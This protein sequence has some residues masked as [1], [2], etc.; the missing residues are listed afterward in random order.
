MKTILSSRKHHY[1][2]KFSIFLI[3]VALVTGLVGCNGDQYILT[4]LSTEGGEVTSPGEGTSTYP[5]GTVVNL[6][7]EAEEGYRFVKWTGR[8]VGSIANVYAAETTINMTSTYSITAHFVQGKEIR[9]WKDLYDIRENLVGSHVLM[10][11]LDYTIAGYE[12]LAS[13]TANEGKGW[14]PIG[15]FTGSFDGQGYEIR[16][17]FID[18]PSRTAVGLFGYVGEGGLVED[19]GVVNANVTGRYNVGG[20]AGENY[21]T[22]NSSNSTGTVTGDDYVGGL[23]GLNEGGSVINSHSTSSVSGGSWVGGL[24]GWNDWIMS[25]SYS[26]GSVNGT[27]KVGGLVGLN[28]GTVSS[29]SYS[30]GNVTGTGEH[31]G[32]LVGWNEGT[33]SDSHSSSNVTGSDEHVGGLVGWNEGTV[34]E[35]SYST[36]SVK[37]ND[38][39]GG[40]V[41]FN[42]HG[43]TV[44][45]SHSIGNVI[46]EE[47]SDI[48][49]LVGWNEGNVENSYSSSSVSGR[50]CV[51]GLVGCNGRVLS[52]SD[53][54]G[55][56]S[57]SSSTGSVTGFTYVGGLVGANEGTVEE[58]YYSTGSV[59]GDTYVGGLVGA[60]EGTVGE[61]YS[62]GS[63]TG[64]PRSTRVGG[65][66]GYNK[67][68]EHSVSNSYSTGNVSG[69]QYVGG[70]VGYNEQSSVENSYS[71]GTVNGTDDV[72]GL[73]GE[74]NNG[75]APHSFW[76]TQTSGQNDS[77]VGTGKTT[78]EMM[79]I[80]TFSGAE[81]EWDIVRVALGARNRGYIWNI[82][83]RVAYP[84][85]SWQPV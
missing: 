61:S 65:L 70:L 19:I 3:T 30:T 81:W 13:P 16:D 18:R 73:V 39:V 23:V 69:D 21:G 29:N 75:S 63:V 64:S 53:R 42:N 22:M 2:V 68:G 41:G 51:G 77:P 45:K 14:Q 50:L 43:G 31:V 20:L 6:T 79:D 76:D 15:T 85:L 72:G 11:D 33:V 74:N 60:N 8:N 37:G 26:T 9:D 52:D 34:E 58:S 38:K 47:G 46:S 36:G 54:A 27:E 28:G 48:G 66:V 78:E 25:D 40:L 10:N 55:V 82:V 57:N 83:N 32:G 67:G 59:T 24:V 35:N 4:I 1:L 7:A 56:V 17:L 5:A 62:T 80:D 71:T 84:R 49:G 44:S 12:E